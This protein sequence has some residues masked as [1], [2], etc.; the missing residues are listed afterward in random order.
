MVKA[1]A[2]GHL[3]RF[4]GNGAAKVEAKW[5]FHLGGGQGEL[6]GIFQHVVGLVAVGQN[7]AEGDFG[8]VAAGQHFFELNFVGVAKQRQRAERGAVFANNVDHH[9][10]QQLNFFGLSGVE[11]F[12]R[13]VALQL[14]GEVDHGAR[15]A[16][17]AAGKGEQGVAVDRHQTGL[18]A[19][20]LGAR[21]IHLA[22]AAAGKEEQNH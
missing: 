20:D 12:E 14:H 7:F 17:V 10:G 2:Q 9:V 15:L 13:L 1:D 8:L 11:V 4:F 22:A 18:A 3:H 19:G 16:V 21:N 5:V 6:G